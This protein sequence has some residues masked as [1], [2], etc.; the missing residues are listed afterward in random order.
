MI[1]LTP[2][3]NN[4]NNNNDNLFIKTSNVENENDTNIKYTLQKIQND[5]TPYLKHA[6]PNTMV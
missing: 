3:F 4:N 1:E 2:N 5:L 6:H